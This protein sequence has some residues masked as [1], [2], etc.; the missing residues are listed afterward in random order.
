[1]ALLS[2]SVYLKTY[3]LPGLLIVV[4]VS[5]TAHHSLRALMGLVKTL[6]F[7]CIS[8]HFFIAFIVRLS[9]H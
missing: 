8:N 9:V 2:H 1:M 4:A 6:S 7:V 3:F 5:G